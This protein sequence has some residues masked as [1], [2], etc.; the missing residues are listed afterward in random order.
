MKY[1]VLCSISERYTFFFLFGY[2]TTGVLWC[3]NKKLTT[4][5]GGHIFPV[6]SRY[7]MLLVSG[8]PSTFISHW[9]ELREKEKLRAMQLPMIQMGGGR[10]ERDLGNYGVIITIS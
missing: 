6:V 2:R 9:E 7:D 5:E 8:N 3:Y 10:Q 1:H 4:M